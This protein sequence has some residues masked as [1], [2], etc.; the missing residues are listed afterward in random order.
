[1]FEVGKIYD[2]RNGMTAKMVSVASDGRLIIEL[3]GDRI[4]CGLRYRK[5]DGTIECDD[6]T[7]NSKCNQWDLIDPDA[8]EMS[9][10]ERAAV[11]KLLEYKHNGYSSSASLLK[12]GEFPK[13]PLCLD[14]V[15]NALKIY[16]ELISQ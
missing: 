13:D 4:L 16:R 1:M 7:C 11:I 5:A 15:K 8:V 6:P 12:I 3:Q 9:E 2:L 10:E 14:N